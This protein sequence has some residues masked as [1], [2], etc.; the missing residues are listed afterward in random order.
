MRWLDGITDSMHTGDNELPF[1]AAVL[2]L[3]HFIVSLAFSCTDATNVQMVCSRLKTYIWELLQ[4]GAE[5]E[6]LDLPPNMLSAF[7]L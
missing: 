2:K 5:V 7:L 3:A 4:L 1:R 6:T